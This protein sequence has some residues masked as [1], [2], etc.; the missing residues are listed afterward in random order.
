VRTLKNDRADVAEQR[1]HAFRRLFYHPSRQR[2]AVNATNARSL[3]AQQAV[4]VSQLSR[5]RLDLSELVATKKRGRQSLS[6]SES[7][8]K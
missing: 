1:A 4:L 8:S 3:K 2:F 5:Q 7:Y 6:A